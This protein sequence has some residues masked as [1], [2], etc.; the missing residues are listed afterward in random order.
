MLSAPTGQRDRGSGTQKVPVPGI[1]TGRP[2]RSVLPSPTSASFAAI[3]WRCGAVTLS[4]WQIDGANWSV[5]H[6]PILVAADRIW[7]RRQSCAKGGHSHHERRSPEADIAAAPSDD[8]DGWFCDGPV[9]GNDRY[10]RTFGR[11]LIMTE[12]QL[13]PRL[14]DQNP[15]AQSR[16][17]MDM[18]SHG[19]S[20]SLFQA[21]Q[22]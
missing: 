15:R 11:R 20:V 19:W 5:V 18:M 17:P 2:G 4:W 3:G 14:P 21:S 8:R 7:F 1:R 13:I 10:R 16:S 6:C 12:S 22:Q 9:M